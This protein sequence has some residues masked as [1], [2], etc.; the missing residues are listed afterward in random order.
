MMQNIKYL[1]FVKQWTKK[2]NDA[3]IAQRLLG[4][5]LVAGLLFLLVGCILSA[6]YGVDPSAIPGKGITR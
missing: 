6:I 1:L 5:S 2:D 3:L 4:L